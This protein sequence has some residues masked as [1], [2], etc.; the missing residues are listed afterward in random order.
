MAFTNGFNTACLMGLS[1][2]YGKGNKDII[3][4]IGFICSFMLTF[5]IAI[6]SLIAY[7]LAPSN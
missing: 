6:G 3:E 7:P 4:I 2:K 1:P 5:G